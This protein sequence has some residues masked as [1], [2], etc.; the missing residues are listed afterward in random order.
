MAIIDSIGD[1]ADAIRRKL[2]TD[3]LMQLKD[4]PNLI[5]Q[6][7]GEYCEEYTGEYSVKPGFQTVILDTDNK[8]LK[9]D[10]V[11]SPI[12]VDEVSNTS[13]GKTLII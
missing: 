7:E 1:V 3:D 5:G 2:N 9:D 11:I 6:I 13:D 8:K 12:Q 10:V 4:M